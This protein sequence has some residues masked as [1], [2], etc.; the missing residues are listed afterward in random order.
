MTDINALPSGYE[1]WWAQVAGHLGGIYP[2][3]DTKLPG[4]YSLDIGAMIDARRAC[5]QNVS[6]DPVGLVAKATLPY[7]LGNRTL[8]QGI[9]RTPWMSLPVT[10]DEWLPAPLPPHGMAT[11]DSG[12]FVG[13]LRS[14]LLDEAQAYVKGAR[15]VGI[16]LSGGMDSRVVAGVVRALQEESDG[17]FSVVGLT[18]GSEPSRDVVY[19]RRITERFGWDCQH[20]PITAD[21]LAANIAYMGRMGAEVSPLHL[22]AMPEVACTDGLDVV[23]AGSYGDS[24]GRA[25]FSGRRVSQLKDVL[26]SRLDRFGVVRH[27]A[28]MAAQSVLYKDVADNPHLDNQTP[29]IRRREIEQ[30]MHY[31]RRMLQSCMLCIAKERRFYQL[32]TAPTVFGQMWG[33][34]PIIRDD[35]W[36]KR[37]LP[38]LPGNLLDI[39]WARTGRRYDRSDGQPDNYDANYHSYGH[40]LRGELREYVLRRVNSNRIRELD[41]FNDRGLDLAV[42]AWGKADTKTT[43]S[44]D[45]LVSWLASLHDFL[46]QYQVSMPDPAFPSGIKDGMRAMRGGLNARLYVEARERMRD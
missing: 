3:H 17:A 21:T 32:F 41:V 6:L 4:Q 19:A 27:T 36:Y 30:E 26:P 23:L 8:L 35:E 33:L 2:F 31:M 24:V 10:S 38:L 22:H 18:W 43:N 1:T 45:E 20:Y 11:P 28:L 40:W 15:T 13:K 12:N 5:G 9:Q 34:D 39:P 37:L 29:I 16:L 44:L 14:A 46:E 7:L 42:H 25:E